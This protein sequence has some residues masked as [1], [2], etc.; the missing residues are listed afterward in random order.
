MSLLSAITAIL[1]A[2]T[3]ISFATG[4]FE[5]GVTNRLADSDDY[6][7]VIPQETLIEYADDAPLREIQNARIII[8]SAGDWVVPEYAIVRAC[9]AA[10]LYV[11]ARTY[12]GYSDE[13]HR[14]VYNIDV[15]QSY[16]FPAPVNPITPTIPNTEQE[17]R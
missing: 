12:G 16:P 1:N 14:H 11:T 13:D 5:T 7:A 17:E 4:E 3:E 8:Y 9:L 15:A 6:I 10:G 2:S